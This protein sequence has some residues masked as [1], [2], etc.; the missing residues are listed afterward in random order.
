LIPLETKLTNEGN[1]VDI[2]EVFREQI[3]NV[4]KAWELQLFEL[5]AQLRELKDQLDEREHAR[6]KHNTCESCGYTCGGGE[7]RRRRGKEESGGSVMDRARVKTAGREE[8]RE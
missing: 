3:N 4:R 5:E 1:E 6:A 7:A 2:A 8:L